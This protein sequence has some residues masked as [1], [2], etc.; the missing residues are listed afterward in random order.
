MPGGEQ[1][2][3]VGAHV[4][5]L[6]E[7]P[8]Q[9]AFA[10]LLLHQEQ[11]GDGDAL[12]T[13][14][15]RIG[16]GGTLVG[17]AGAGVHGAADTGGLQPVAPVVR[18]GDGVEHGVVRHIRRFVQA[19]AEVEQGGAAHRGQHVVAE[20][21]AVAVRPVAGAEADGGVQV[22][23]VEVH[24]VQRGGEQHFDLRVLLV[25][26]G[27]AR[28]QPLHGEG[29][30]GAHLDLPALGRALELARG[31]AQVFDDPRH[32]LEVLLAGRGQGDLP[33]AT[34]EQRLL[35]VILQ[36]AD[37]PRNG[38]GGDVQFVGGEGDAE[39]PGDGFESAYG[40][41]RRQSVH[42]RIFFLES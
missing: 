8:H 23:L 28:N 21:V 34:E 7:G 30:V 33:V 18:A 22:F 3:G 37:L 42:A 16:H 6:R 12:A 2:I 39:V 40:I 26:A 29:G 38:P 4:H 32:R 15:G 36:G 25:E 11:L 14:G 35:H 1:V 10:Q 9:G 17:H 20:H 13:G 19:G 27:Q 41:E 5:G 24:R 31:A